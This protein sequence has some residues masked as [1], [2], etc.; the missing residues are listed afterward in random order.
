MKIVWMKI[1][2]F[3]SKMNLQSVYYYSCDD[4]KIRYDGDNKVDLVF[5]SSG[6]LIQFLFDLYYKYGRYYRVNHLVLN[7]LSKYHIDH[8]LKVYDVLTVLV[9]DD[10]ANSMLLLK[11][12][13][14]DP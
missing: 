10:E 13:T 2:D 5:L 9:A 4:E 12:N 3:L 7:S 11:T 8:L 6:I 14:S 1:L